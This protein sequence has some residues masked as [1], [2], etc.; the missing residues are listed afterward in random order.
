MALPL[1]LKRS[2]R[3][4]KGR[5][6]Y[7][8]PLMTYYCAMVDKHGE[9][10]GEVVEARKMFMAGVMDCIRSYPGGIAGMADVMKMDR[11]SLYRIVSYKTGVRW[12]MLLVILSNLGLRTIFE[13]IPE[14][15][16]SH[17]E[18]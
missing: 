2:L 3:T 18:E 6:A 5:H 10:H 13:V 7:L 16:A 12:E 15:S 8:S 14:T 9:K 17:T 11:S 4:P 1:T